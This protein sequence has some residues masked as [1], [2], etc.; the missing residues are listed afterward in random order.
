MICCHFMFQEISQVSDRTE[1][2][3]FIASAPQELT[4][5]IG[6]QSIPLNVKYSYES[7]QPLGKGVGES[8]L[9]GQAKEGLIEEAGLCPEGFVLVKAKEQASLARR[10]KIG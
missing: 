1:D 10:T 3:L 7:Y 4:V 8:V 6:G 9:P 2:T 5:Y